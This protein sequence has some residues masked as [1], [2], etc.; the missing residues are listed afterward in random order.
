MKLPVDLN[1]D[2]GEGMGNEAVLMPFIT[3]ANIA[4]GFHAGDEVIMESTVELCIRH[5]V[6]IGAHPS[7]P[8]RE[9]FGRKNMNLL[10]G[11]V[12][13]MVATQILAL[14]KICEDQDVRLNH[15]KPHG[16]LYNMAACDS[17]LA[18][19]I[20]KA[21][22]LIDAELILVG[23]SGSMMHRAAMAKG[24]SFF[25]EVFADRS[26]RKDGTLTPRSEPGAVL[27]SPTD[28]ADQAFRLATGSGILAEGQLIF[29]KA[30]TICIHGDGPDA[31]AFAKAINDR[32][33]THSL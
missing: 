33:S 8:D 18:T 32:L 31:L 24:L 28:V 16:A 11:E 19:A 2:M 22:Y 10:P 23:L 9:N 5:Q 6:N 7:F 21:V 12:E 3:S 13:E 25:H 14:R 15:V 1:C 4:C 30:D 29:P 27:Q 20:A 17:E 26:Y